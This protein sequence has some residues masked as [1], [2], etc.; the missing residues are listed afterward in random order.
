MAK[1]HPEVR[2]GIKHPL[3][4]LLTEAENPGGMPPLLLVRLLRDGTKHLILL[5]LALADGTKLLEESLE[6]RQK[7]ENQDGTRHPPL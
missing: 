5:V 6:R 2:V 1:K 3:V 4:R 7:E